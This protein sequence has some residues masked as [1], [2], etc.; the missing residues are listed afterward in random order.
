MKAPLQGE[1]SRARARYHALRREQPQWFANHP[2]GFEILFADD[3]M[4]RAEEAAWHRIQDAHARGEITTPVDKRWVM[5]G[6]IAEDSW[7][8]VLRDAV[9]TPDG[10][11]RVYRREMPAPDR[12]PGV[13]ALTILEDKVVL[14]NHYRHALRR[15]SWELP[16]GFA[17]RGE[18]YEMTVRRQLKEEI[19]SPVRELSSLGFV[20]PDGGK[21]G[22]SVHICTARIDEIGNPERSEAIERYEL[23]NVDELFRRVRANEI[24]DALTLAAI[25]KAYCAGLLPAER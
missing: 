2:G 3:E 12:S 9:R 22:D 10:K 23:I 20:D 19:Q 4:D 14:L 25:G 1:Q 7:G 15:F 17:E 11:L 21:L 5:I 24:T 6:V 13:V 16:R 18:S 8:V